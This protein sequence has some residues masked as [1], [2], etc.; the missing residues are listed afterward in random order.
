[1]INGSLVGRE[2]RIG[3][4][5]IFA[6]NHEV[7]YEGKIIRDTRYVVEGVH[8]L[9][10]NYIR[11]TVRQLQNNGT[12]DIKGEKVNFSRFHL[13]SETH[14]G[15]YDFYVIGRL[16]VGMPEKVNGK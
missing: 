9:D 8:L 1:M 16:G 5:V 14:V 4:V 13:F 6:E 3:D 10:A 15:D 2:L 7:P 12:Y 11:V